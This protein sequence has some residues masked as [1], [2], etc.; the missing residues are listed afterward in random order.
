MLSGS[1]EIEH[2][3]RLITFRAADTKSGSIQNNRLLERSTSSRCDDSRLGLADRPLLTQWRTLRD[4]GRS[5]ETFLMSTVFCRLTTTIT[6]TTSTTATTTT[7]SSTTTSTTAQ[8]HQRAPECGG[9]LWIIIINIFISFRTLRW[10]GST[11]EIIGRGASSLFG[12]TFSLS[13]MALS[14]GPKGE[15][16]DRVTVTTQASRG[17]SGGSGLYFRSSHQNTDYSLWKATKH[18]KRPTV[19]APPIKNPTNNEWF[20][21][22]QEKADIF[23]RHLANTFKPFPGSP[24]EPPLEEVPLTDTDVKIPLVTVKEVQKTINS[25]INPKKAPGYDLITGQI[26]KYLPRK[27]IVKITQ[28]INAAIKLRLNYQLQ[29]FLGRLQTSL[30]Y[31]LLLKRGMPLVNRRC[32]E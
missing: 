2:A 30:F 15:K 22:N 25:E 31:R 17:V 23:S 14:L 24:D 8:H 3:E 1:K 26:L 29:G 7:S 12:V 18:L 32:K 5:S 6:T 10:A 16:F 11:R 19:Q 9:S 4:D 21:T 20:K 27:A 28:I 13:A